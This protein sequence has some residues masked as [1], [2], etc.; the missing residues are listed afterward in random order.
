MAYASSKKMEKELPVYQQDDNIQH[1]TIQYPTGFEPVQPILVGPPPAGPY[2][3]NNPYQY[4]PGTVYNPYAVSNPGFMYSSQ[5]S[6][7][8]TYKF[9]KYFLLV[10][11][12]L[13][14]VFTT[15]IGLIIYFSIKDFN[16]RRYNS[17]I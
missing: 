10:V 5:L 8:Y 16:S 6:L 13:F 7:P 14:I 3:N 15:G 17:R 1:P 12:G 9:S 2:I 4:N 11:V